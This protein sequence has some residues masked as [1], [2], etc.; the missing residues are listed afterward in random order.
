MIWEEG[1]EPWIY[2]AMWSQDGFD[3]RQEPPGTFEG[4]VAEPLMG[5]SFLCPD[6]RAAVPKVLY[7]SPTGMQCWSGMPLHPG[8][9]AQFAV[10]AVLSSALRGTTFAGRLF[11][12]DMGPP[13]ADDLA[14]ADLIAHRVV[15]NLD[16][17]YLSWQWQQAAVT[18][19][20]RRLAR[21]LHDGVLQSLTGISLQLTTVQRL[22][23]GDLQTA[24]EHLQEIQ[25]VIADEQRHIRFLVRE[26]KSTSR[27]APESEFGLTSLLHRVRQQIERQWGLRV[28]LKVKLLEPQ[29]PT[30]LA[31]EIYYVVHEALVN[32]ARHAHASIVQVE[33][34]AQ[35]DHVQITVC[36]NGH[37]FPF[38]G[39]YD[40]PALTDLQLG[41][42]MLKERV[43]SLGGAL[44]VDSSTAGA[45]LDIRL[46]LLPPGGHRVEPPRARL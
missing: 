28:D 26:L 32:A 11:F 18:E 24:R 14:L 16:Q 45:R 3:L 40:L 39:H 5:R 2:V 35:S 10:G 21:N 30:A 13:T 37:G 42:V 44:T 4:L 27:D 33:L 15:A 7:K 41:P 9:Q 8:L 20:R 46:P 17:F 34:T 12:L 23:D 1:E 43:A 36:D 31:Y 38:Y 19:E 6:V 25:H 29:M 22:L